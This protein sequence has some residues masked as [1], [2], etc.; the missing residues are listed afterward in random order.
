[1]NDRGTPDEAPPLTSRGESFAL[2]VA[3]EIAFWL[4]V[5]ALWLA[6]SGGVVGAI[7]AVVGGGVVFLLIRAVVKRSENPIQRPVRDEWRP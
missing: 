2:G 7:V 6:F 5:G 1:M 4:V 3:F